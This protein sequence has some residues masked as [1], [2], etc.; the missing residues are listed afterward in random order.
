LQLNDCR[1]ET[2]V[3][4]CMWTVEGVSCEEDK[5]QRLWASVCYESVKEGDAERFAVLLLFSQLH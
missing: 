1:E 5:R 2:G 4:V 3:Y